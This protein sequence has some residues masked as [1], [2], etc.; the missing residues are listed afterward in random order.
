MNKYQNLLR[1]PLFFTYYNK[2]MESTTSG[3]CTW[4]YYHFNNTTVSPDI[5]EHIEGIIQTGYR[6][7]RTYRRHNT[8]RLQMDGQT[9]RQKSK[10]L[11]TQDPFSRYSLTTADFIGRPIIIH[12]TIYPLFAHIARR[13]EEVEYLHVK[14]V[15][16]LFIIQQTYLSKHLE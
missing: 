9:E 2:C 15:F 14:L 6:Y 11:R 7:M 10:K 5:W 8:D 4:L 1:L 16:C 12:A 3:Q 13:C